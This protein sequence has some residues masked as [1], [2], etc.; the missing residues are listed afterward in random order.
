MKVFVYKKLDFSYLMKSDILYMRY[1]MTSHI[2]RVF[3]T[4]TYLRKPNKCLMNEN[5]ITRYVLEEYLRTHTMDK[6]C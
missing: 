6:P 1:Y 4:S 3:K 5:D 2:N